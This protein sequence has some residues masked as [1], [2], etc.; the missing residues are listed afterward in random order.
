MARK[1]PPPGKRRLEELRA[2]AAQDPHLER[3]LQA[4]AHLIDAEESRPRSFDGR[5]VDAQ[6]DQSPSRT[7][8]PEA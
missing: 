8:R 1:P 4:V 5:P 6:R 2:Q 7:T 3:E